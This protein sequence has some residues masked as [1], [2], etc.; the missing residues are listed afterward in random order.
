MPLPPAYGA[1]VDLFDTSE[2][3]T[4]KIWTNGKPIYRKVVDLGALPDTSSKNV[5]HNI[6]GFD[7]FI[8]ISGFTSDGTTRFP[9][10]AGNPASAGAINLHVTATNVVITTGTNR[11]AHDGIAIIEYTKT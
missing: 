4:S 3:V 2:T 6:T 5:A 8:T 9:L 10:P 1:A 11:L 7:E